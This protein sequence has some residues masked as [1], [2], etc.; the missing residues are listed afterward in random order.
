MRLIDEHCS[1]LPLRPPY[2]CS[3]PSCHLLKLC[4]FTLICPPCSRRRAHKIKH[5]N[6]RRRPPLLSPSTC[7]RAP[8]TSRG[9]S[10]NGPCDGMADSAVDA[11]PPP[12]TAGVNFGWTDGLVTATHHRN[13]GGR[14]NTPRDSDLGFGSDRMRSDAR[15]SDLA[16]DRARD[17]R[18]TG[19]KTGNR[20]R[21]FSLGA[22]RRYGDWA[23][24]SV[25]HLLRHHSWLGM[26]TNPDGARSPH[27]NTNGDGASTNN[28]AGNSRESNRNTDQVGVG[29]G[30]STKATTEEPTEST[31]REERVASR[32][33]G[34]LSDPRNNYSRHPPQV[35]QRHATPYATDLDSPPTAVILP[36]RQRG[37]RS[38]GWSVRA[39]GNAAGEGKGRRRG[40]SASACSIDPAATPTRSR[41][42]ERAA[43]LTD[44]PGRQGDNGE[45]GRVR[46]AI[47]GG[48][49]RGGIIRSLAR[50]VGNVMG[51]RGR[52]QGKEELRGG[53]L[54][55]TL[56]WSD[57]HSSST[58]QVQARNETQIR[59]RE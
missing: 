42:L 5:E 1:P 40:R 45:G 25:Q 3:H 51:S 56:R 20:P 54:S 26:R 28:S 12:Y 22:E 10:A 21:S 24:S 19:R 53:E 36:L 17:G 9:A 34:P 47:G 48:G 46:I 2:A 49:G 58:D 11:S 35:T 33:C 13:R 59:G 50:A 44:I 38:G 29:G 43:S 8:S 16:S 23:R 52:G 31:R 18:I 30:G 14:C 27:A 57:Q 4:D 6:P 39:V 15:D 7:C 37:I 32:S 41:H 55:P